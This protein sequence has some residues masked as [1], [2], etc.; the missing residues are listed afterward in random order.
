MTGYSTCMNK[1]VGKLVNLPQWFGLLQHVKKLEIIPVFICSPLTFYIFVLSSNLIH[2]QRGN[3]PSGLRQSIYLCKRMND[4][5]T[6]IE[7]SS[8]NP[9]NTMLPYLLYVYWLDTVPLQTRWLENQ[10]I[11]CSG[12]DY[13]RIVTKSKNARYFGAHV[14]N[15]FDLFSMWLNS[16]FD[17]IVN[18]RIKYD[19]SINWKKMVT[20]KISIIR[21]VN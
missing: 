12:S 17:T 8:L 3:N 19:D 20:R 6:N 5:I 16:M 15:L 4:S 13:F 11:Y 7:I 10:P 18:L 2:K 9:L 1:V 21:D 14:L